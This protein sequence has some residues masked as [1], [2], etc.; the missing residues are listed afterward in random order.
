[1]IVARHRVLLQLDHMP[2]RTKSNMLMGCVLG[3][4]RTYLFRA[5]GGMGSWGH[6]CRCRTRF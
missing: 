6:Q 3:S 2:C 5:G 1:M 4:S